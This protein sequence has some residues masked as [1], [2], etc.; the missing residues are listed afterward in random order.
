MKV[1]HQ[2]GFRDSWNI[3]SYKKGVG[4]GL[5][6]SPVNMSADKLRG[7]D[8]E[9]KSTSFMDPQLYLLN[10]NKG[11]LGTYPYFPENIMD[12][13]STNDLNT[14][15]IQL[16]QLCVDFQLENDFCYLVIPT[17]Y[18]DDN[19]SSYFGQIS[20]FFVQPFCS[21]AKNQNVNKKI[22][23]SV[24]VKP[25]MLSDETRRNELLNWITSHFS[26]DGVYIIFEDNFS[27]KQIKDFDYLYNAIEVIRII[28]ANQ[29][30][31]HVGYCNTEAMLYS[32]G[33]PDSVTIGSYEN[34]RSFSVKRFQD[35]EKT[36]MRGPKARL[37]SG[38][39]LQ[40]VNYEYVQAM[41]RMLPNFDQLFE[42][43]EY[44]PLMFK[45]DFKWHFT[46]PELY[47]HYF[48]VFN[49]QLQSLPNSR[50]ERVESV[51]NTVKNAID[52]YRGITETVLLD[53]NSDGSH[54]NTWLNVINASFNV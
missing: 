21:V 26:I 38:K 1:F 52:L 29:L 41:Q 51:K 3:E 15:N 8:V 34:L 13:F 4:N 20:D 54:L 16:A 47:K 37:F 10:E 43:S 28:K 9:L 44:K 25:I 35:L 18:H 6:F 23:L 27:S 14:Q 49:D 45:S 39:L 19:P 17:R 46:K 2:T 33:M 36:E 24:I 7:L 53:E 31:V 48:Y 22:L 50:D 11:K 30:E 12:G 42:D 32:L 40:W 5:I